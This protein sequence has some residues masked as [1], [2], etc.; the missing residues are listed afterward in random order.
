MIASPSAINLQESG[1]T[2]QIMGVFSNLVVQN[3]GTPLSSV[4]IF[5]RRSEG[6]N[7]Q[8][9]SAL[10]AVQIGAWNGAKRRESQ[11]T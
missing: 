8:A 1:V 4:S 10:E 6:L 5:A 11:I 9:V 3:S 7:K 2:L